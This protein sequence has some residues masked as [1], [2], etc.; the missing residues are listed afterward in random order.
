MQV[1]EAAPAEAQEAHCRAQ[2][3]PLV[4]G[5]DEDYSGNQT[6]RIGVDR[7]SRHLLRLYHRIQEENRGGHH[8]HQTDYL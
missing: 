4:G 5:R 3:T 8:H 7:R 2:D 1:Y 6:S